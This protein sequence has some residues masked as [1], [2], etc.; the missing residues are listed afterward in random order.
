MRPVIAAVAAVM[1]ATTTGAQA[2]DLTILSAAAVRP[3][4][5]E[6]PPLYA[7]ASGHRVTVSFGNA[8]AI[9]NKVTAG[10][11]A[12]I[13]ILPP[14][15]L[16]P[17]VRQSF[18]SAA[19]PFGVVR[20]GVA[21]RT[22]RPQPPVA[23]PDEFR[24]ALLAA[25]TFG[26]PDPADGSTSSTYLVKLMNELGIADSMRPKIKL[27]PDGTKA[28]EAIAQGEIALTVAPITSIRVVSGV[29][30]IGPLPETLQLKTVYAAALATKAA[31]SAAA[32]G[33]M[34]TLFSSEVAALMN[35]RGIDR[36]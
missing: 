9:Q 16:D 20:L 19:R 1:S 11:P 4:L 17:L 27:F 8:T 25:P 18:M 36:P 14:A 23:T 10:E 32:N 26:M 22:G 6:V 31:S 24:R 5:I 2:D 3:A 7:K 13:V 28:L 15:Q 34:T 12:D 33:L 21:G 29:T 35:E 30:L